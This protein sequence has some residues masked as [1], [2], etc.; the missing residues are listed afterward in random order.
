[1]VN[2][3]GNC[4]QYAKMCAKSRILQTKPMSIPHNKDSLGYLC[5]DETINFASFKSAFKYMQT[6]CTKA[7]K[8]KNPYEHCIEI[9]GSSIIHDDK[10]SYIGCW[11]SNKSKDVGGHGH[12][13]TYA[14]GCTTAPSISDYYPFMQ[15]ESQ[16]KEIV[17]N[18]NG[19]WYQL[20][21]LPNFKFKLDNIFGSYSEIDIT[22]IRHYFSIYS[23]SAQLELENAI[24][25]RDLKAFE[26]LIAK[27]M[28]SQPSDVS[29]E[30]TE[31]THTFWLKYGEKFGVKANT[32]FSN[33]KNLLT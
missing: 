20:E 33:F 19:E 6:K 18:S 31:L 28:P 13:D 32:N 15:S 2:L 12:P 22:A 16:T 8:G 4:A 7:L 14:K 30:L 27:Y 10:G 23:K 5:P 24:Q 25:S 11:H 17:F 26:D 29:K 21:K 9:K 3:V 1:M